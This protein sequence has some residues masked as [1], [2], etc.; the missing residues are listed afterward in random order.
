MELQQALQRYL[1]DKLPK[2]TRKFEMMFLSFRMWREMADNYFDSVR[3][4]CFICFLLYFNY[5]LFYYLIYYL[6]LVII[7]NFFN[8]IY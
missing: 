7:F 4:F 6:I 2:D 8:H 1:R 5:I 3:Y